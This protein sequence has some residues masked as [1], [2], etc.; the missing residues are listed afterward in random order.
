QARLLWLREGDANF[1]YFHSVLTSRRRRN[2]LA[3]I[4]VDG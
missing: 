2:A 1:K 4:M 3:S